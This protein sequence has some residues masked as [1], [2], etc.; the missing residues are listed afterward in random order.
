[1]PGEEERARAFL[2]ACGMPKTK[3]SSTLRTARTTVG[4]FGGAILRVRLEGSRGS[5][6]VLP[7]EPAVSLSLNGIGQAAEAPSHTL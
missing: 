3:L 5:T 4:E 6:E 1:V 7:H 2:E